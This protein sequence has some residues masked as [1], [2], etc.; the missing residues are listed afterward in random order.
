MIEIST[1]ALAVNRV[2]TN[3]FYYRNTT[4][5]IQ[6]IRVDQAMPQQF[7]KVVFPGERMLFYASSKAS[8]DIY[9]STTAGLMLVGRVPCSQLQ[10]LDTDV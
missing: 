3:L 7:E 8:L 1:P 10:V 2:T 6:I 5:R 4:G 9:T